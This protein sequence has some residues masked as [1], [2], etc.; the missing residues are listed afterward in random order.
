MNLN[1]TGTD[2]ADRRHGRFAFHGAIR[3]QKPATNSHV[4]VI[5]IARMVDVIRV[6]RCLMT[7][8]DWRWVMF[9]D[10]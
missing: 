9:W 10:F 8:K 7:G 6:R 2:V 1:V 3:M 5:D 4:M